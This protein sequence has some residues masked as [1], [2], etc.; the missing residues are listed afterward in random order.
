M[1]WHEDD[2][3]STCAIEFRPAEFGARNDKHDILAMAHMPGNRKFDG[4]IYFNLLAHY[5]AQKV[6]VHELGHMFGLE[7]SGSQN[8][9]MYFEPENA[10][11]DLAP[12]EL[13][14]LSKRHKL[15]TAK[16]VPS[17]SVPLR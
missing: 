2:D 1:I 17:I 6:F 8:S 15:A 10:G 14:Q 4:V 9:P 12:F 3:S 13:K 11:N 16:L 5:D 7:H